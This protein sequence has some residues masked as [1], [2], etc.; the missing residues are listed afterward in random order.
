MVCVGVDSSGWICQEGIIRNE[1]KE[2]HK[3][4]K[5]MGYGIWD[6]KYRIWMEYG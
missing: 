6:M 4:G 2:G 1:M 3:R 5:C